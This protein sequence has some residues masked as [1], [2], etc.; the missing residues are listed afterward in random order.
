MVEIAPP[1]MLPD[2]V[3]VVSAE[4]YDRLRSEMAGAAQPAAEPV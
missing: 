3:R 2:Y 1:S 4:S